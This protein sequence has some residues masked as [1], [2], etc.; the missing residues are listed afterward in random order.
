ME[1]VYCI[2]GATSDIGIEYL[3]KLN[4][5]GEKAKIIAIY[6]GNKAKLD[7]KLNEFNNLEFDFMLPYQQYLDKMIFDKKLSIS[8]FELEKDI[9]DKIKIVYEDEDEEE[10]EEEE[11]ISKYDSQELKIHSFHIILNEPKEIKKK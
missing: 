9:S 8:T 7:E 11:E 6:H 5:K 4:S 2:I 10:I 3:K 1:K